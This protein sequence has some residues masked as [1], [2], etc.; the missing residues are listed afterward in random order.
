MKARALPHILE[1]G[2]KTV[3]LFMDNDEMGDEC[4]TFFEGTLGSLELIDH[5]S[6]Y[7]GFKI[8]MRK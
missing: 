5:R 6:E 3:H 2:Y 1:G 7:K 4:Q 8:S